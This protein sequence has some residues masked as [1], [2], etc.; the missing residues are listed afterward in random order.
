MIGVASSHPTC[1]KQ[2]SLSDRTLLFSSKDLEGIHSS[3]IIF[4]GNSNHMDQLT[5]RRYHFILVMSRY[6]RPQLV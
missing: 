6:R 5:P 4:P 3:K 2:S 1:N